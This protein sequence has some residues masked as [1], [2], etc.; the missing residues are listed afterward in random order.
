VTSDPPIVSTVI[1]THNSS[2]VL[3]DCLTA[4]RAAVEHLPHELVVVDNASSDAT[5]KL[6]ERDWPGA[7]LVENERNVGFAA[8]CNWGAA[9][10]DGGLLLFLNPDTALDSNSVAE[11]RDV[12][13]AD[14]KIGLATGRV[15]HPDGVFQSTSRHF[16][17]LGN[18]IFS[19]GSALRPLFGRDDSAD[20]YTLSDADDVQPVPAVAA[21]FMMT[22]RDLF[23]QLG[24]FDERY[25]LFM[26]DTDL[27]RRAVD[28]G[29]TNVFVPTAGAIHAWGKG[30]TIGRLRRRWHHHVSMWRYLRKYHNLLIAWVAA[31]PLLAANLVVATLVSAVRRDW[32]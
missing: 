20:R 22:R 3:S 27:S 17:T 19:R 18:L 10:A 30:S 8:A 21:T 28:R 13:I 25:F 4:L 6:V 31:P 5:T 32:R 26:E 12:V 1:V 9:R 16:P 15:R 14:P 2:A 7:I 29:Y 11:L 23:I 24:G